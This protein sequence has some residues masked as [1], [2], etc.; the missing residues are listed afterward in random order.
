MGNWEKK[1]SSKQ[2]GCFF[3]GEIYSADKV[4]EYVEELDG[5]KTALCPCCDIDSVL[6]DVDVEIS[7]DLLRTLQ[8]HYFMESV[9]G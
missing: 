1:A 9:D 8:H 5:R 7:D 4:R 3:C 2:A 6:F